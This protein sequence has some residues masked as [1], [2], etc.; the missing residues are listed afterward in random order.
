MHTGAD[1]M[2]KFLRDNG[3]SLVLCAAFLVF[4]MAQS[5]FGYLTY[6]EER[7]EHGLEAPAFGAYIGSSHFWQATSEN[8]ESEFLQMGIYV[9]FASFL[10]QRGSAESKD[11]DKSEDCDEAV[12][13]HAHDEG[14][15]TILQ[16]GKALRWLYQYSLGLCFLA[17][18][19][20]SF[21]LHAFSSY[22]LAGEE[23]AQHGRPT[24]GFWSHMSEPQF[25]FESMQNWQ[26]EFLAVF[27]IVVLSIWLRHHASPESKCVWTPHAKTGKS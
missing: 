22:V 27:A 14:A 9:F 19:L 6:A 4:W 10:Y 16:K 23:A 24:P 3:L 12:E 8:W 5:W 26:S 7:R 18:F 2:K 21:C 25:W 13:A 17:L 20:V 15:P 11:P 1:M